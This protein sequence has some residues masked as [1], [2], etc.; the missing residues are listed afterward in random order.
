MDDPK[1][2]GVP[3]EPERAEH[4]TDPRG[5][6]TTADA[7]RETEKRDASAEDTVESRRK[8]RGV[9]VDCGQKKPVAGA[10]RCKPCET[11]LRNERR[12]RG[13]C[14]MCGDG[15]EANA[16]SFI[17]CRKCMIEYQR[18]LLQRTIDRANKSA[19]MTQMQSLPP[20]PPLPPP[21]P[22]PAPEPV[23]RR[24]RADSA[25]LEAR[26]S[27]YKRHRFT[28]YTVPAILS[29]SSE[30]SPRQGPQS[31]P[32][33]PL[34]SPP[35]KEERK[36]ALEPLPLPKRVDSISDAL[37]ISASALMWQAA[38]WINE[39][40]TDALSRAR[41]WH[42]VSGPSILFVVTR[43]HD[44]RTTKLVYL[45][46]ASYSPNDARLMALLNKGDAEVVSVR[47]A[48][49]A[50][51]AERQER[52]VVPPEFT[53]ETYMAFVNAW[54]SYESA[55]RVFLARCFFDSI[56]RDCVSLPR[57]EK[58]ATI[59]KAYVVDYED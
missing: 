47:S 35:P 37:Q 23:T 55:R 29:T 46:L 25:A 12:R 51:A 40:H 7:H 45:P 58:G 27:G 14:I 57:T 32:P 31:P 16:R 4:N 36:G 34:P 15:I 28:A 1:P 38:D 5:E 42:S 13:V 17:R 54:V 3:T 10:L 50:A 18:T 8:A 2:H 43:N 30:S 9:C 22:P 20:L 56:L 6:T 53:Q 33:K 59:A 41:T 11:S 21:P 48:D 52:P 26:P 24:R 19:L 49:A 44:A 39:P